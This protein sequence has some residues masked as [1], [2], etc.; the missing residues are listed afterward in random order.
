MENNDSQIKNIDD[1]PHKISD[2]VGNEFVVFDAL[3]CRV[4][5]HGPRAEELAKDLVQSYNDQKRINHVQRMI[6]QLNELQTK[7]RLA[8]QKALDSFRHVM[9]D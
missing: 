3:G 9:L 7:N 6:D 8:Y 5:V 2:C 4:T 1:A